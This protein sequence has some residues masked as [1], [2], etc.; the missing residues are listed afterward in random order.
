MFNA[1]W[2]KIKWLFSDDAV[3]VK[4]VE[5]AVVVEKKPEEKPKPKRGRKKKAKIQF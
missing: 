3:A 1:I 2:E 4:T 5:P